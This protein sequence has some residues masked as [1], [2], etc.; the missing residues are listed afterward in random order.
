MYSYT[1]IYMYI[2]KIPTIILALNSY[3]AVAEVFSL[4]FSQVSS[5][6]HMDKHIFCVKNDIGNTWKTLRPLSGIQ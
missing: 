1:V 2:L 3:M 4:L 6:K 5:L